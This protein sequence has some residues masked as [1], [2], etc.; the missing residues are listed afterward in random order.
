[1]NRI[2]TIGREFGSG[3]REFGRRLSETLGIAYYD[4]EIISEIAKRTEMSEQYV[5]SIVEHK[6]QISFPIHVGRSFY[7]TAMPVFDQSMTVYQEQ[8]R[9]IT[10]MAQKSDCVI[11]GRCAD[12]ILKEYEPF[13]VFIYADLESRM[14]RCREKAPEEEKM[15]DKELKQHI[16]GID[17]KR[18]KY[19]EFYT[20]HKWGDRLNFDLCINTSRTK[21]KEIVP[22]MSKLF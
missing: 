22:V 10:E 2:I 15:T 3:G 16:L 21:I 6:P 18:A 17:R 20:G 12:Y 5:R 1:M 13:R 7:P 9:I 8:S 19:Y 11:V 14:K 4:Q